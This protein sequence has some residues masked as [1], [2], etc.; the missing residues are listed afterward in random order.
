MCIKL[1]NPSFRAPTRCTFCNEIK[2]STVK[3]DA[4]PRMVITH[5]TNL[6]MFNVSIV[7][8]RNCRFTSSFIGSKTSI[9]ITTGRTTTIVAVLFQRLITGVWRKGGVGGY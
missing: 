9:V 2:N 8:G 5:R 6:H 3:V 1:A 4:I 7:A